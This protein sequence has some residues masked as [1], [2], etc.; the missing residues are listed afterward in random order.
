MPEQVQVQIRKL[1][2][3]S[4]EV[5]CAG[6]TRMTGD[7]R[8]MARVAV[9]GRGAGEL[10]VLRE[11]D[12]PDERRALGYH[13]WSQLQLPDGAR[14]GGELVIESEDAH[15]LSLPWSSLHD[16]TLWL[17]DHDVVVRCQHPVAPR[18]RH[19]SA[20][21]ELFVAL[22]PVED[23]EATVEEAEEWRRLWNEELGQAK[24][25]ETLYFARDVQELREALHQRV[26]LA[27][28]RVRSGAAD[29][30]APPLEAYDD[31]GLDELVKALELAPPR[32]L[33]IG[34]PD[35]AA[36]RSAAWYAGL[37]K[38]VPSM[39]VVPDSRLHGDE[40]R[41]AGARRFVETLIKEG[42]APAQICQRMGKRRLPAHAPHCIG[43]ELAPGR[44]GRPS[45][46][47]DWEVQLDRRHQVGLVSHEVRQLIDKERGGSLLLVWHGPITAGL[48]RLHSR[49][50][51]EL[52]QMSR[53]NIV[54]DL[55]LD[56]PKGA[57]P[58]EQDFGGLYQQKLGV[59]SLDPVEIASALKRQAPELSEEGKSPLLYLHHNV[60]DASL[61]PRRLNAQV[62]D[63]YLRWWMDTIAENRPPGL[64][65]VLALAIATAP[66]HGWGE[67]E[68]QRT[69]EGFLA[70]PR[71]G[72]ELIPLNQLGD[73]QASDII[74]F[75]TRFLPGKIRKHEDRVSVAREIM[76]ITGGVYE[77][78][79]RE[80]EDLEYRWAALRD[81]WNRRNKSGGG[82]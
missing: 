54:H 28:L 23:H 25:R 73:V 58:G 29:G 22:P 68:L 8:P 13:L 46:E 35:E 76:E 44:R 24:E 56:W 67:A 14:A 21:P 31:L 19:L 11:S 69:L 39:V 20:A 66:G 52:Q 27:Y 53:S 18:E 64:V 60:L 71:P 82:R 32:L 6:K 41:G 15:I 77:R 5:T 74:T 3:S 49:L 37:A 2:D 48:H 57:P 42:C 26:D 70:E 4:H 12:D 79:I 16:G 61:H 36:A 55:G 7:L 17:L 59:T 65:I 51:Q 9:P 30:N 45:W 62:I 78:V 43:G 33:V 47:Q 40:I 34:C 1:N 50:L 10:E 75:L 81:A 38:L 63:D 80:L 72:V